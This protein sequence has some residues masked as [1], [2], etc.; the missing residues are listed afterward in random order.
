M[1]GTKG[2]P[3]RGLRGNLLLRSLGAND[4]RMLAPLTQR[5]EC[6]AGDIL[7]IGDV[8]RPLVYFPETL[9]VRLSGAAGT[10]VTAG[11]GLVGREGVIGW[12]GLLGCAEADGCGRV[13]LHGGTALVMSVDRLRAVSLVSPTLAMTLLRFARIHML[14]MSRTILSNLHDS[15]EARVSGWLLMFHDR[16][17]G[18]ELII[19]HNVLAALLDIRRASVTC[20]LHVLEGERALRCSRNRILIRDR[21]LLEACA[22]SAYGAAERV[23]RSTIGPFGKSH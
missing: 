16:V 9:I 20:A 8:D 11:V 3:W 17:E 5:I 13:E 10:G 12:S 21:A 1:H 19:T 15:I 7:A 14:Q 4:A 2:D 6:G 18:D 22:G 23:Y